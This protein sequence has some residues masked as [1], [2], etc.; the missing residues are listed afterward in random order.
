M[1]A[2]RIRLSYGSAVELGLIRGKADAPVSTLYIFYRSRKCR[3]RCCFCPQSVT[4]VGGA[5]KISRI[6][7][8]EFA[9][10]EV[11]EKLKA[12]RTLERIC[13]QCSDEP[14]VKESA[15]GMVRELREGRNIPVSVSTS[16]ISKDQMERLKAAGT[17]IL[18]IPIDCAEEGI[19]PMIKGRS[20][21]EVRGALRDAVEVFGRGNVGTHI[22]VGLGESELDVVLLMIDLFGEG[23]IPSLFAFTPVEGTEMEGAPKPSLSSYR[24]LQLARHLIVEKGANPGIF[25]FDLECRIAK[26]AISCNGLKSIIR[27]SKAF[28]VQG[29]KGCNRPYYN[30]RASGPVYNYAKKPAGSDLSEIRGELIGV[31]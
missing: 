24:R 4:A 1:M 15:V 19:F 23:V 12:N 27:N 6:E 31:V 28:M 16:P 3:G 22:I 17:G 14:A 10:E 11:K 13:L 5:S 7:W 2:D 30:E 8:P 20:M 25:K 26:V 18:T 9:L 29:C 21:A